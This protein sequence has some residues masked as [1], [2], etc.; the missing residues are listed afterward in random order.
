MHAADA[1]VQPAVNAVAI[2]ATSRAP[3]T[4]CENKA[5]EFPLFGDMLARLFMMMAATARDSRRVFG[6]RSVC[7]AWRDYIDTGMEDGDWKRL[8]RVQVFG[9]RLPGRLPAPALG[10]EELPPAQERIMQ[11]YEAAARAETD[12][13]AVQ[14]QTTSQSRPRAQVPPFKTA[15]KLAI[16][17]GA[18]ASFT[19][20]QHAIGVL[21]ALADVAF[22][23]AT[24]SDSPRFARCFD[25]LTRGYVY[26]STTVAT[27]GGP[28]IG[29]EEAVEAL[30]QWWEAKL[31]TVQKA[32][33]ECLDGRV[34]CA[35]SDEKAM[36]RLEVQ[37]FVQKMV[38]IPFHRKERKE[39]QSFAE[40]GA[41]MMARWHW[42]S[43]A[44]A[45][46]T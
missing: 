28:A 29:R 11:G 24:D 1:A 8:Y 33:Q 44:A 45:S 23:A 42:P 26:Y 2:V 46:T 15:L 27:R 3:K 32:V 21:D 34:P 39:S 18:P 6:A 31:P 7:K 13:E 37:S 19:E 22:K 35:S 41:G 12:A 30:A 36:A 5:H 40:M 10:W 20:P 43:T 4:L 17:R 9:W 14:A 38:S 16:E 25:N